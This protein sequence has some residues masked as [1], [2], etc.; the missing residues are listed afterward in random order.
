[1]KLFSIVFVLTFVL[2]TLFS[3]SPVFSADFD[4]VKG[5]SVLELNMEAEDAKEKLC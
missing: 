5:W 3:L 1:M 2:I 4:D